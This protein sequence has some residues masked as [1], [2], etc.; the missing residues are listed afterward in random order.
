[1]IVSVT[2]VDLPRHPSAAFQAR[3]LVDR[4]GCDLDPAQRE[5]AVLAVNELVTDAYLHGEGRIR[6]RLES[7]GG[8]LHAEI[9]SKGGG[10]PRNGNGNVR[11]KVVRSLSDKFG[12]D[13]AGTMTWLDIGTNGSGARA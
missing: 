13:A 7:A 5:D 3:T 12:I 11:L 6:L 9:E 2:L 1:V 10:V 4:F 8:G